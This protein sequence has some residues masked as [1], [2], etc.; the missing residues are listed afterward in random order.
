VLTVDCSVEAEEVSSAEDSDVAATEDSV[1]SVTSA[2]EDAGSGDAVEVEV[3]A[4]SAEELAREAA[5]VADIR[6]QEDSRRNTIVEARIVGISAT[7]FFF[8]RKPSFS[9]LNEDSA[10]PVVKSPA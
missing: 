4:A 2:V 10:M 9:S 6:P 7:I 3:R 8:T 5:S 1:A